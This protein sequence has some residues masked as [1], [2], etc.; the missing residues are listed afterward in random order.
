MCAES[1][2]YYC[3]GLAWGAALGYSPFGA[4]RRLQNHPNNEEIA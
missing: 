3:L 2:D 1:S 4:G